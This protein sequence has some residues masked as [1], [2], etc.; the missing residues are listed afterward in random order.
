MA[1]SPAEKKIE[2]FSNTPL[3]IKTDCDI[4]CGVETTTGQSIV[5]WKLDHPHV[6]STG[7]YALVGRQYLQVDYLDEKRTRKCSKQPQAYNGRR[8]ERSIWANHIL[9]NGILNV[10]RFRGENTA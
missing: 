10:Q 8:Y 1:F 2:K 5:L 4:I 3:R 6:V 7:A 9:L